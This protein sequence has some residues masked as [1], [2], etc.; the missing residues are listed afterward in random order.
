MK[1]I[2]SGAQN[3]GKQ[4]KLITSANRD[5]SGA[6]TRLVGQLQAVRAVTQRNA[7]AV[8]ETRGETSVLRQPDAL[9][10]RSRNGA[11]RSGRS[12]PGSNGRA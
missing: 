5:H 7:R 10:G 12:G 9:A 11:T 4:I 3:V 8:E 6:T 2:S 1:E